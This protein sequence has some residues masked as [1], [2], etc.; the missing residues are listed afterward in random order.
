[1][2]TIRQGIRTDTEVELLLTEGD[3]LVGDVSK[4]YE[5]LRQANVRLFEF[6]QN[7]I[8]LPMERV[9]EIEGE[10]A[11]EINKDDTLKN[12]GQRKLALMKKLAASPCWG[13]AKETLRLAEQAEN[14]ISQGI[15]KCEHDI[16]IARNYLS[17]WQ[18]RTEVIAGLSGEQKEH[19]HHFTAG[20]NVTIGGNNGEEKN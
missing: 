4:C 6:K 1:M 8:R 19:R 13:S 15:L 2:Q 5:L 11:F 3:K 12:A 7:G 10:I 17:V 14:R 9:D 20:L 16:K 18:S